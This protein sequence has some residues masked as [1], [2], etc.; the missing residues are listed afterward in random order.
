MINYHSFKGVNKVTCSFMMNS[1]TIICINV[2]NWFT[3]LQPEWQTTCHI[4]NPIFTVSCINLL[5]VLVSVWVS[6]IGWVLVLLM[7]MK[8]MNATCFVKANVCSN[9]SISSRIFFFH[10]VYETL[11]TYGWLDSKLTASKITHAVTRNMKGVAS[12]LLYLQDSLLVCYFFSSNFGHS[13]MVPVWA[14]HSHH[15]GE[16]TIL[17]SA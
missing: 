17:D 5:R 7:H 16:S 14:H 11:H 6:S 1:H 12:L 10:F 8:F 2:C 13:T 9:T 3:H 15:H 4:D